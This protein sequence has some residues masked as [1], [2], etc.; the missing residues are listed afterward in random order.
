MGSMRSLKEEDGY[1]I[2]LLTLEERNCRM[3]SIAVSFV[4]V[5]IQS[6]LCAASSY[7]AM[8]S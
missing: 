4:H 5:F 8:P 1:S 2:S 3:K 6:E 7:P